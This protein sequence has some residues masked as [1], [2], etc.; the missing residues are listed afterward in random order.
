VEFNLVI[1]VKDPDSSDTVNVR[2]LVTDVNDNAPVFTPPSRAASV[3]EAA[4]VGTSVATFTATD[5]DSG[6][7]GRFTYVVWPS[8][9]L[10]IMLSSRND[11]CL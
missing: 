6:A 11:Q 5:M 4:A 7:N 1:E 8:V 2:F 9:T 10:R 3:S